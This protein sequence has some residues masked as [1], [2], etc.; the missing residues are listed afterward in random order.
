[1][2][3]DILIHIFYYLKDYVQVS[4]VCKE[5]KN[6]MNKSRHGKIVE[7][8]NKIE[9]NISSKSQL[10]AVAKDLNTL[11][12]QTDNVPK[13]IKLHDLTKQPTKIWWEV[14]RAGQYFST[15]TIC[16]NFFEI[17]DLLPQLNDQSNIIDQFE[18]KTW[19]NLIKSIKLP[20]FF[21]SKDSYA[22]YYALIH[23]EHEQK[24]EQIDKIIQPFHHDFEG[25]SDYFLGTIYDRLLKIDLKTLK[26]SLKKLTPLFNDE[27]LLSMSLGYTLGHVPLH[28]GSMANE[29]EF[30]DWWPG[31]ASDGKWFAMRLMTSIFDENLIKSRMKSLK[32]NFDLNQV[33]FNHE[34]K[35]T[36]DVFMNLMNLGDECFQLLIDHKEIRWAKNNDWLIPE[37]MVDIPYQKL[38]KRFKLISDANKNGLKL[39]P[40]VLEM[41]TSCLKRFIDYKVSQ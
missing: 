36:I 16:E 31:F 5:W 15:E 9:S 37:I 29:Y 41:N 6:L 18:P 35:C 19:K 20:I 13:M 4:L 25:D 28:D 26:K 38:S 10:I 17:F 7:R 40:S 39:H 27:E 32:D 33:F 14:D 21:S 11:F 1:M 30:K 2:L 8:L 34:F 3:P 12:Y 24:L 23:K 22:Y